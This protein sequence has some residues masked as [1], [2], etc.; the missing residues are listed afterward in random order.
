MP[1]F[2][3]QFLTASWKSKEP[4][5]FL[6]PAWVLAT[7]QILCVILNIEELSSVWKQ[8]SV[9]LDDLMDGES[10]DSFI[11]WN[12]FLQR[13][14]PPAW[15]DVTYFLKNFIDMTLFKPLLKKKLYRHDNEYNNLLK[16]TQH[17]RGHGG[18]LGKIDGNECFKGR[19]SSSVELDFRESVWM[20]LRGSGSAPG[21]IST[22]MTLEHS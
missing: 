19:F 21:Q 5:W 6:S 8:A 22:R 7:Q 15:L 9:L 20:W 14:S 18:S 12:L 11:S 17:C 3:A 2:F 1:K 4:A 13:E 10:I 16:S